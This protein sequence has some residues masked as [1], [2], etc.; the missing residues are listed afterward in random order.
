MVRY[1]HFIFLLLSPI[2]SVAQITEIPVSVDWEYKQLENK[3]YL[4]SIN[5]YIQ[6]D[7]LYIVLS[8]KTYID[9]PDIKLVDYNFIDVDLNS[10][11][12]SISVV[13]KISN[14]ITWTHGRNGWV[15]I[16]RVNP[17]LRINNKISLLSS[18]KLIVNTNKIG[19]NSS[20]KKSTRLD[21]NFAD[22]SVLSNGSWVKLS[23]DKSG[24]YKINNSM[25]GDIASKLGISL[26][27]ID[28]RKIAI[29]GQ[30]GGMLPELNSDYDSDDLRELSIKVIG[31][32]DGKF[33]NGDYVL[34]YAEGASSWGKI[35]V[36]PA[37]HV[38]NIYDDNNYVFITIKSDLGKR[39][40]DRRVI[41]GNPVATYDY[42]NSRDAHELDEYNLIESGQ[43]WFGER[44]ERNPQQTIS[45]EFPNRDVSKSVTITTRVVA[46]PESSSNLLVNA[47]DVS[48]Y[49]FSF[50]RS[51]DYSFGFNSKKIVLADEK[52]DVNFSF[53][54]G[55]MGKCLLDYIEVF[56]T[57]KLIFENSQFLFHNSEA[58]KDGGI[59]EYRISNTNNLKYVWRITDPINPQ[60]IILSDVS[61]TKSFKE[62]ST[63]VE[64]YQLITDNDFYSPKVIGSVDN[65]NLHSH[66]AVDYVIVTYKDFH[67]SANIL[68][69]FHRSNGLTVR[70]V[71]VSDI[72]NEYSSGRQ[73]LIAIRQYIRMIYKKGGAPSKLKYLLLYGDASYDFKDRLDNNTNFVPSYQSYASI[74]KSTSFVSDDYFGFMDDNEGDNISGNDLLDVAVGRIPIMSNE[75]GV[76]VVNKIVNYN[77]FETQGDW[78][79]RIQFLADDITK[80][81]W[82]AQ[83]MQDSEELSKSLNIR[84]SSYNHQKVY[85]DTYKIEKT[86]GGNSYPDAHIDFMQNVQ[87]GNLVTNYF[88]HGSEV[89]WTGEGLFYIDDVEE[90]QNNNNLPLFITVTCE[91]SRYDNPEKFTGG[92][93]LLIFKDGGGI[94]LISTTREITVSFGSMINETILGCLLP[95]KSTEKISIGEV[96]R[97]SKNKF[98]SYGSRRTVSLI[99]DPALKLA[100]PKKDI[101]VTQVNYEDVSKTDT[102]KSLMKVNISGEVRYNGV[103]DAS[104]N[105]I[106][107]PLM[108]DKKN[109]L[110]SLDNNDFGIKIPYWLQK[111]VVYKGKSAIVDGEFTM[112]FVV[113]KD[114]NYSYGNGKLSL[115]A[116]SDETGVVNDASGDNSD[117]LVGGIDISADVDDEGPKMKIYVNNEFFVDGG[118]TNSSPIIVVNLEDE[119]GINT[120]GNGI[121]HDLKMTIIS[122]DD[123]QE[124]ILNEFY[125]SEIDDFTRGKVHYQMLGLKPGSYTAEVIAWDVF[126]N[127]STEILH[128]NVS[129]DD[130][131]LVG[132]VK[133]YPNPFTEKTNFRFSHNHPNQVL[134]TRIEIFSISG[135]LVKTI[136]H[137]NNYD[138]FVVN[139][140]EWK[141]DSDGGAPLPSGTY[142]YRVSTV[143]EEGNISN[144]EVNKLMI[145]R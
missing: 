7:T 10:I 1:L 132:D 20:S 112:E 66:S 84:N 64:Y 17:I 33:D 139:D 27:K 111:N 144:Q 57:S 85:L 122:D 37:L 134:T 86:S 93:K 52:I 45:F 72:Y 55:G 3:Y 73:D 137:H 101:I 141:G 38:K 31:E 92:E 44:F 68:A 42:Y 9:K 71:D 143:S 135:M 48:L 50:R 129:D 29:Y 82:E 49:N 131:V 61:G 62:E 119:S 96:L 123:N 58:S 107:Y 77:T 125:E 51:P 24:V 8:N 25:M 60:S 32:S 39:I 105:G 56:A 109:N 18:F 11:P 78:R 98:P 124:I 104:F 116:L 114:I 133:N 75:E 113:P 136:N 79:N 115:Y 142:I 5:Q 103:K 81:I 41:R 87:N 91:F 95:S 30:R 110:L 19:E 128:F 16:V 83:L 97:K 100:Y 46:Q 120:V 80:N 108:Y 76:G 89:K 69:D 26:S 2:L 140:I 36:N 94:G 6:D 21:F 22:N 138:G 35:K 90:F 102:I 23:V 99:G 4:E 54:H 53:S 145:I 63:E 121:G 130:D 14:T 47:N 65:Q 12:D 34:F 88:G 117:I 127:S 59:S 28:P 70:V 15:P 74:S 13:K 67:N 118:M 126:N 40:E 106:A 43:Q